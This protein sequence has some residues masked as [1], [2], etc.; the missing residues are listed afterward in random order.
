MQKNIAGEGK[1]DASTLGQVELAVGF[2]IK[3][4]AEFISEHLQMFMNG[5]GTDFAGLGCLAD[6]TMLI[7]RDEALEL[8]KF[9]LVEPTAF[10]SSRIDLVGRVHGL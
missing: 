1:G 10:P 2:R 6:A 7:E 4:D 5:R 8:T 9:H 3:A